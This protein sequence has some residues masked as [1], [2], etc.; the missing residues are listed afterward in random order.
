MLQTQQLYFS[1]STFLIVGILLST[2]VSR[3]HAEN[4]TGSSLTIVPEEVWH[5]PCHGD[6]TG[7]IYI[8]ARGGSPPYEYLWNTGEL[9]QNV[10]NLPAGD[11]SVTVTDQDGNTANSHFTLV[12]SPPLTIAFD[13]VLP[14]DAGATDGRLQALIQGGVPPY[15]F[16]WSNGYYLEE[17]EN[18]PVGTY[19]VTVTDRV[20]C[21]QT[22]SFTLRDI[23]DGP[24]LHVGLV[25][26]VGSDWT[27]V[28]LPYYY[29]SMVVVAN[30]VLK[31]LHQPPVLTRIR[32]AEDNSFEL[33]VQNPGDQAVGT[34]DVSFVVAE[35]GDFQQESE[36]VQM[37][38]GKFSSRKTSHRY[39]WV[40]EPVSYRQTYKKPVVLAQVM[41]ENDPQWSVAWTQGYHRTLA[42]S[43]E[44][45][46]INKHAGSDPEPERADETIGYLVF[47]AGDFQINGKNFRAGL[48]MD[49]MGGLMSGESGFE[50]PLPGFGTAEAAILTTAGMD[51]ADGGWP[52]LYSDKPFR[53]DKLV[54]TFDEDQLQDMDRWHSIE[55]IAFLV[56]RPAQ[57]GSFPRLSLNRKTDLWVSPN[58]NR[59]TFTFGIDRAGS[60]PVQAIFRDLNGRMVWFR[61]FREPGPLQIRI[62]TASRL[63]PGLYFLELVSEGMREVQRVVIH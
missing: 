57:A 61:E 51:D 50:I 16:L 11:Y 31:G 18:L 22:A 40:T 4:R 63:N 34:Y 6:R 35:E 46:S 38:A 47:E 41:T 12:Q 27:R 8:L 17:I 36:G 45:L 60:E 33:R 10:E 56:C 52:V 48:S 3:S 28:N 49:R 54:M 21:V 7:A 55:Q 13:A 15:R 5:I 23:A 42:P 43:P 53:P 26:D 1:F 44:K 30:P 14:S 59:G 32:R 20:D 37:E 58:P 9:S 29:R 39:R 25:T 62:G 24:K 19:S 2:S